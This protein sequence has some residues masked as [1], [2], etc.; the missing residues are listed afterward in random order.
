MTVWADW[1]NWVSWI[2]FVN[3]PEQGH[4]QWPNTAV[5]SW[6]YLLEFVHDQ[7]CSLQILCPE[8]WNYHR[9]LGVFVWRGTFWDCTEARCLGDRKTVKS[10]IA[11]FTETTIETMLNINIKMLTL[12]KDQIK[13]TVSGLVIHKFNTTEYGTTSLE[14]SIS[15][16]TLLW[17]RS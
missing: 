2:L 1:Q 11:C 3:A 6:G 14:K 7:F 17:A 5:T 13:T 10:D 9:G 4:M 15:L 16:W 8:L 12:D